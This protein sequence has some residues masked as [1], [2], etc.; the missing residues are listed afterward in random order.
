[1]KTKLTKLLSALALAV[2]LT[3]FAAPVLAQGGN[4]NIKT[5]TKI[6]YHNGPVMLGSTNIYLIWYGGWSGSTPG[7]NLATQLLVTDLVTT[8]GSSR[9]FQINVDYTNAAGNGPSGELLYAGSVNDDSYSQ[10]AELSPLAIQA[11]VIDKIQSGHFPLDTT[12]IYVVLSTSD[13]SAIG[14]GFCTPNTPPHH[15]LATFSGVNARYAFI[16]NPLRCPIPAAPQFTLPD[17]TRLPTPNGDFAADGIASQLAAVISAIVTNPT[18]TSWFDRYGLEN[19]TKCLGTFG[20]TYS[21]ANGARANMRLG[22]HDWLIQQ[23]W[24]NSPRKGFCALARPSP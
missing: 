17:G 3:M 12:G 23:N 16:G 24:V 20:Q 7:N 8:L 11:I 22:A 9:Y 1:M 21:T 6:L 14:T 5:N 19:T 13:V 15:G 18:F 2:S 10:G 4:Q